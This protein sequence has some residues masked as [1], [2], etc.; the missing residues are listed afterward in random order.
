MNRLKFFAV[1]AFLFALTAPFAVIA[2]EAQSSSFGGGTAVLNDDGGR[3]DGVRIDV[4]GAVA[5]P[6]DKEYVA[7]LVTDDGEGFLN[8]GV[9]TVANGIIIHTFGSESEGYNGDNLLQMYGGLA[10]TMEDSGTGASLSKPTNRGI[11]Y[12]PI[13]A[14]A[15]A[16]IRKLNTAA[17]QTV[18]QLG[19]AM[20]CAERAGAAASIE[21]AQANLQCVV[22]ILEGV[23]GD[24]YDDSAETGGDGMGIL[25]HVASMRASAQALSGMGG[26]R[27]DAA[28]A[29]ASISAAA[30][31]VD[32]WTNQLHAQTLRAL[33]FSEFAK[34][35]LFVGP[36]G[37]TVISLL[38]AALNGFDANGDGVL[39]EM[40]IPEPK[41]P[42]KDDE[43]EFTGPPEPGAAETG[44][45]QAARGAQLAATLRTADG[46]LPVLA[47]PTPL[48]TATPLP[49]PTPTATPTP[50]P[51]PQPAGP[52]LPGVGGLTAS[53]SA[54]AMA[55]AA[56]LAVTIGGL[57]ALR[58]NRRNGS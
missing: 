29:S 11:V 53:G 31:N 19:L 7:W 40:A 3:N 20:D 14:G 15:L 33:D 48:P 46:Q 22:N 30:A 17:H 55:L 28:G 51:I 44:A 5:P 23:S 12:D 8:L 38:D 52:G 27:P 43:G 54:L 37:N 4:V 56:A 57:S 18:A 1:L 9:L 47:T 58:A 41:D 21:D 2:V 36:G 35:Q 34:V 13:P 25:A 16:E 32:R 24:N 50:T 45:K 10:V 26:A 39:N 49:T 42:E 6:Q